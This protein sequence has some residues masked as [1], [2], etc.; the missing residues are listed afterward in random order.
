ME[1]YKAIGL[2]SGTSLDGVDIAACQ[3]HLDQQRWHFNILHSQTF[4]YSNDWKVKLSS[5]PGSDALTFVKVNSEYGHYLGKLTRAF[6]DT[7]GFV[8]DLIAS[9]GHT[10]FHQPDN[11][12]TV[13]IGSGSAIAAE[14][15]LPVVCDFRS[16]D[17]A[18]GGQGAP[19]VPFG[20]K[21]L[22]AEYDA[23]LNLGGFANISQDT[24]HQRIAFDICPAN[25]LLN[26]ISSKIG[27]DYDRDGNI[28][29]SGQV[30]EPLL[31]N[32]N[33]TEFYSLRYPKSLGREWLEKEILPVIDNS[34]CHPKDSLRTVCEHIAIQVNRSVIGAGSKKILVT[35]GG[36]HNGFL[37]ERISDNGPNNWFVGT[38][39]LIDFKEALVFAFL[40]ILRWRNE[41]NIYRSVTGAMFNH[42]GGAVYLPFPTLTKI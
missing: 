36:A 16:L 19:L 10:I 17:V 40:G 2:M 14:T 35:G 21:L 30:N 26:Y 20:D 25:I 24:D 5:L 32:L 11:G 6:L 8:P 18:L 27:L 37:M 29:S 12:F 3:F 1:T 28:A 31:K 23:C 38:D 13:Q 22:F 39:E 15:K 42:A 7:T 34:Q 33:D 9:H 41:I 4:P